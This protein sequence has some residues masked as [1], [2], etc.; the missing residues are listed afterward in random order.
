M[1][2][3]RTMPSFAAAYTDSEIAAVSNYVLAHFGAKSGR[4]TPQ[5]VD[6]ARID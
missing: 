6:A 3:D 4:V 2:G 5:M 1:A